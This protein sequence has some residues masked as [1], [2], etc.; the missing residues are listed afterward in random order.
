MVDELS[1][2]ANDYPFD[3]AAADDQSFMV[4]GAASANH[5]SGGGKHWSIT[6]GRNTRGWVSCMSNGDNQRSNVGDGSSRAELGEIYAQ[7]RINASPLTVVITRS[8]FV[9]HAAT[10]NNDGYS[11]VCGDRIRSLHNSPSTLCRRH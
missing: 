1:T 11:V 5:G 3:D 10:D 2:F 8:L 6:D 7:R 4:G 9:D